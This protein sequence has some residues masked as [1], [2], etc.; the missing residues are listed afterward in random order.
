MSAP[1]TAQPLLPF[2]PALQAGHHKVLG[3]NNRPTGYG[4]AG[5]PR[6][7]ETGF[8]SALA[9]VWRGSSSV[10]GRSVPSFTERPCVGFE[11]DAALRYLGPVRARGLYSIRSRMEYVYIEER[12]PEGDLSNG[13][14][15]ISI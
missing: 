10:G 15:S 4:G 11:S 13:P 6:G 2:G 5:V 12:L 3:R 9:L 14:I 8:S 1:R 7:A